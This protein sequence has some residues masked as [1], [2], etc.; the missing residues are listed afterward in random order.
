M[1]IK[2]LI[3]EIIIYLI[4]GYI[5][6]ILFMFLVCAGSINEQ[7][8]KCGE[9]I[10]ENIKREYHAYWVQERTNERIKK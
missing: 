4:G 1:T 8:N 3:L 2:T 7:Q 10:K 9:T 5:L 6:M